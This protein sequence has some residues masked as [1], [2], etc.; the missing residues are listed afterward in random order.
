MAN[1]EIELERIIKAIRHRDVS[2][3]AT[4]IR[5][6]MQAILTVAETYGKSPSSR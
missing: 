6:Y 5:L 3:A 1:A 4:L 2:A